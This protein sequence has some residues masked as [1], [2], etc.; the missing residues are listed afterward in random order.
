MAKQKERI[1][2]VKINTIIKSMGRVSIKKLKAYL[3]GLEEQRKI[4]RGKVFEDLT[5]SKTS[6]YPC[7]PDRQASLLRRGF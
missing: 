1:F 4:F 6:P 3:K 7:L 2:G 5:N